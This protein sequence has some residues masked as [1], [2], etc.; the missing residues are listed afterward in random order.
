MKKIFLIILFSYLGFIFNEEIFFNVTKDNYKN[1][2]ENLT[3]GN[4][5]NFVFP[6]IPFE[7]V[8]FALATN[9][10]YRFSP[11]ISIYNYISFS[12]NYSEGNVQKK[13][14][15]KL[16]E[17][18]GE[19]TYSYEI[20]LNDRNSKYLGI[21]ISMQKNLNYLTLTI[22]TQNTFDFQNYY[23][24]YK[25]KL[26]AFIPYY[27][28][29]NVED[30]QKFEIQIYSESLL[31]QPFEEFY[32]SEYDQDNKTLRTYKVYAKS[33][34]HGNNLVAI[35]EII[36]KNTTKKISY[37]FISNFDIEDFDISIDTPY[38]GPY[39]EPSKEVVINY[40]FLVIIGFFIF[41]A[42]FIIFVIFYC[43]PKMDYSSNNREFQFQPQNQPFIN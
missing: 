37:Q 39:D 24:S 34:T 1:T 18:N 22:I 13:L 25:G 11:N 20:D 27:F 42:A 23:G 28:F 35:N 33:F 40:G 15:N 16:K 26:F 12:S 41:I 30:K 10:T 32:I 38:D 6:A 31:N 5:Y 17:I 14:T 3:K 43:C 19:Y 2:F 9:K 4:I 8:N 7:K 36:Y 29:I 21:Q